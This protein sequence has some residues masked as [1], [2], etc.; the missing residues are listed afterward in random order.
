MAEVDEC[1][2]MWHKSRNSLLFNKQTT[3]QSL[4]IMSTYELTVDLTAYTGMDQPRSDAIQE[5]GMKSH[6]Y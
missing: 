1:M 6:L 4:K 5:I 3:S 2:R